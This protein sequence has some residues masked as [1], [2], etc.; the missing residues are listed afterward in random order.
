MAPKVPQ[1]GKSAS[2]C[3]AWE[4]PVPTPERE[5]LEKQLEKELVKLKN[6]AKFYPELRDIVEEDVMKLV[7]L[8]AK[9]E[10]N[11]LYE[12]SDDLIASAT[13]VVRI[14]AAMDSGAVANVIHPE[15]LPCD[16]S[17]T[18]NTTGK[19]FTGAGGSRIEKFGQCMAKL[20][21]Q[22]G[23]VGCD[24]SLADV[25]RPLH[26]VSQVCGP[27]DGPGKQD[28]LFNNKRCVVVPAGIVEEICRR[29]D[30]AAEY[31]REGNLYVGEF[32]MSSFTLQGANA[33][34]W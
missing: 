10:I 34:A 26:S 4:R 14:R 23:S 31:P 29:V 25:S 1:V 8:I 32:D 15:E 6:I 9:E 19:H 18:P 2:V 24:W 27:A 11:C 28:V 22:H 13:E 33:Y 20:R 3:S 12:E 7:T 17:P 21:G 5:E 16:C 30:I